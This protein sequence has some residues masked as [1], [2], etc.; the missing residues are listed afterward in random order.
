MTPSH[1]PGRLPA[2]HAAN[3]GLL[4][5]LFL[6]AVPPRPS[7]FKTSASAAELA[8]DNVTGYAEPGLAEHRVRLADRSSTLPRNYNFAVA[9]SRLSGCHF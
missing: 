8:S 2:N 5:K 9:D 6:Q 1:T 4:P 3:T 7:L